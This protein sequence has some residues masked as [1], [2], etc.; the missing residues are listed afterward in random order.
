MK[1]TLKTVLDQSSSLLILLPKNPYLDQVAAGLSLY[2]AIKNTKAVS[3]SCPSP[4]LVEFN[5]LVGVDKVTSELG[6]KNLIIKF[7]DYSPDNIERVLWDIAG[8]QEAHLNV[9]TKPGGNPPTK[10]QIALTYAGVAADPVI[11]IGGANDS[12]FPNLANPDLA[13]AKLVHLGVYE[14]NL[15]SKSMIS[16]SKPKGSISELVANLLGE[17]GF[18]LDSDIATNLLAG[19]YEGSK[20]FTSSETKAETFS[21][22]SKLMAIGGKLPV[23]RRERRPFVPSEQVKSSAGAPKSWLEPKIYKGTSVS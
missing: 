6:N 22:A 17:S 8:G 9:I 15:G 19:M 3:V 1:D 2:L 5:R 21:L 20:N 10:D 16:L 7:V 11:L 14:L 18:E 23:V 4:M 13:T 12:H